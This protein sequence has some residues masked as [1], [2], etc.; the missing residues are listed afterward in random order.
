M[1]ICRHIHEINI[2]TYT[3]THTLSQIKEIKNTDHA[4]VP[5]V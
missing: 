3:L 1:Y 2:R 4:D 5:P